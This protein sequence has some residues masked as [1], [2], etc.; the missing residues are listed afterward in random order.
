[1]GEGSAGGG[2]ENQSA[3]A[4]DWITDAGGAETEVDAGHDPGS[5]VPGDELACEFPGCGKPLYYSG[6]GRKPKFCDEHKPSRSRASAPREKSLDARMRRISAG[7]AENIVMVGA[8]VMPIAPVTSGVVVRDAE[9]V[10]SEIVKLAKGKPKVLDA[11]ER[12]SAIGPGVA[13]G[14]FALT[15]GIAAA[16][17]F[18]RIQADSQISQLLGVFSIWQSIHDP[19]NQPQPRTPPPPA[20]NYV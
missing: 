2:Q 6:R 8:L 7:L 15:V 9:H 11:L 4:D 1:M 3:V 18:E 10:A 20:A 12:A 14:R 19:E 5:L 17:D 13:V 16:V